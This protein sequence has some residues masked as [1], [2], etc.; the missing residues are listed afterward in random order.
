MHPD[1]RDP[2]TAAIIGAAIEVHRHIG[3]GL[4]E[5]AY[6]VCLCEEFRLRGVSF[7]RQVQLPIC[8]IG[9][10]IDCAY[11]MDLLVNGA[12]VLELKSVESLLTIHKAQLITY[13]KLSKVRKGL[14]INF[15][16]AVLKDGIVR[17]V[18]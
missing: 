17:L 5:S 14:I 2:E 4:M 16:V 1:D 3:P 13:L 9:A 6:E 12:V 15:N 10:H 7:E 18:S 11:R 8:Y